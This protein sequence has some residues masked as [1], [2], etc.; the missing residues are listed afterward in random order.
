MGGRRCG[1]FPG[2]VGCRWGVDHAG[3]VASILP[4]VWRGHDEIAK[5]IQDHLRREWWD[6]AGS[7][8]PDRPRP[9]TIRCWV[10]STSR[11]LGRGPGWIKMAFNGSWFATASCCRST[12]CSPTSLPRTPSSGAVSGPSIR[13]ATARR[14]PSR[15]ERVRGGVGVWCRHLH[16]DESPRSVSA[17]V[18]GRRP[19]A[20]L[21]AST[22]PATVARRR[23]HHHSDAADI[24]VTPTVAVICWRLRP[25]RRRV[26]GAVPVDSCRT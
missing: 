18:T 14:G 17:P 25:S 7:A 19:L 20:R 24:E 12:T 3:S 13:P 9:V 11:R 1:G 6:L 26:V 21:D 22:E 23:S 2:L 8:G 5:L 16:L 15:L 10:T 4:G